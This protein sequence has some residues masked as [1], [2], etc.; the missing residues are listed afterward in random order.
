MKITVV[1]GNGLGSS[2]MMEI[3]IKKI[4]DAE[5]IE[6]EIDH[7]DLSS[8]QGTHSD[9]FIGTRDITTQFSVKSGMVVSLNNVVDQVAM[10]EKILAA[11]KQLES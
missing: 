4:L 2:L 9:I 5:K 7:V 1:C 11:I 3:M 10:K 8:V 6:Y